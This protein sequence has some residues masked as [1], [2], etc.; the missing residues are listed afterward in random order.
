MLRPYTIAS[1]IGVDEVRAAAY[2]AGIDLVGFTTPRAVDRHL[3]VIQRLNVTAAELQTVIV[4]AKRINLGVIGADDS[5]ERQYASGRLAGEATRGARDLAYFLEAQ[6]HLAVV[7]SSSLLDFRAEAGGS[8]DL[9]PAGQGSSMLR[10]AAVAAGLGT[11]GLNEMLL[12]PEFGPRIFLAGVLTDLQLEPGQPLPAELCLGLEECGRCAAIC[13]EDA[14]PRRAKRGAPL[15][16]YRGLDARA[17]ARSS[18][19]HGPEA[20][21][22]HLGEIIAAPSALERRTLIES[23]TTAQLWQAM[24]Y[25]RQGVFT[26]CQ[27]CVQVCPVGADYERLQRSPRRQAELPGGVQ[28]R[29]EDGFVL[30]DLTPQPP[31]LKG[32]WQNLTPQPPS[33]KRRG[34]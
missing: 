11:L 8:L 19:P 31:S 30:V 2:A 10:C 33:L 6:G 21:I 4:L 29:I 23:R 16:E 25:L 18:Q 17:C 27:A 7:V 5:V 9:C 13:P 15:S 32:S 12:T 22:D 14:I 28:R 3:P 34:S 26:A 20:F 24:S 1:T